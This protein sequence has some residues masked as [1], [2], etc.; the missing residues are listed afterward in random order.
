MHPDLTF[1]GRMTKRA[2]LSLA[3]MSLVAAAALGQQAATVPASAPRTDLY[4]VY[5][6]KAAPGKSAELLNSIKQPG[7]DTPMPT[8]SLILKHVDGDDWDFVVVEHLGPKFTLDAAT[9]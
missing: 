7:T 9:P 1:G 3:S 5:F 2:L 4:A 6:V 8:H